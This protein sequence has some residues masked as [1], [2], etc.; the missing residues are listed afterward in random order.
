MNILFFNKRYN[1]EI[2]SIRKRHGRAFHIPRELSRR[3]HKVI[4]IVA[5]YKTKGDVWLFSENR[6]HWFVVPIFFKKLHYI[7]RLFR[8]ISIIKT[9]VKSD[10]PDIVIAS[11]DAVNIV[12]GFL[13]AKILGVCFVADAKDDY[14]SF[15]LTKKLPFLEFIYYWV[16]KNADLVTC[17]SSSLHD[18]LMGKGV[19]NIIILKNG[20]P[21]GFEAKI[22]KLD[23]RRN[24][25]LPEE[26]YLI[27]SAG[28]L[29]SERNIEIILE[30]FEKLAKKTSIAHLVL[31]GP[32]DKSFVFSGN[33]SNLIYDMGIIEPDEVPVF[34]AA[35]DLGLILNSDSDFGNFC[36]PQKYN[37]MLACGLPI[38]AADVGIFSNGETNEGI[39]FTFD[40]NDPDDLYSKLISYIQSGGVEK[41]EREKPEFFW[42]DR[43]AAL[44]QCLA[45]MLGC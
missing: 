25:N 44:D 24:F 28:S 41:N 12:I 21:N 2:D 35:L 29:R 34:L 17:V 16:L 42:S 4:N 7:P 38:A 9:A 3:G 18:F 26:K 39:V 10:R 8:Y 43:V 6:A 36:Y 30:A 40:P 32:R 27:G 45:K 13:L 11:S 31:A 1:M 14:S 22:S 33:Y 23:A 15:A 37:E 19:R 20:V 5:D